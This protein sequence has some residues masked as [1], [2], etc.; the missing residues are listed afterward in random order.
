MHLSFKKIKSFF[1]SDRG[2][3]TGDVIEEV[4]VLEVPLLADLADGFQE[5]RLPP[6]PLVLQ[7]DDDV[8]QRHV[9]PAVREGSQLRAQG[10][11]RGACS[12]RVTETGGEGPSQGTRP[13]SAQAGVLV[14][15]G[16]GGGDGGSERGVRREEAEHQREGSGTSLKGLGG[17]WRAGQRCPWREGLRTPEDEDGAGR[18]EAG[19]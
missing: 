17:G 13:P 8:A 3:D 2:K 5:E 4:L 16:H 7:Q 19:M 14:G 18:E 12:H 10:G 6:R 15:V 9:I 1:C 11:G